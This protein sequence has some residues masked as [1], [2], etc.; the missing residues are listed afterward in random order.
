MKKPFAK[1][2]VFVLAVYVVLFFKIKTEQPDFVYDTKI[3]LAQRDI[4][5]AKTEIPAQSTDREFYIW[6]EH[7]KC[8]QREI[9]QGDIQVLFSASADEN[10]NIVIDEILTVTAT[11]G[12]DEYKFIT[13]YSKAYFIE[14]QGT[15]VVTL[16]G[17][18]EKQYTVDRVPFI[19]YLPGMFA[20]VRLTQP[21]WWNSEN[22]VFIIT[23]EPQY[24]QQLKDN[25]EFTK[26][27]VNTRKYDY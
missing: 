11:G 16:M 21:G 17:D 1:I 15:A 13:E 8:K 23:I 3:T 7:F 12:D 10:G 9:F 4:T 6:Q 5:L 18:Y 19:K 22:I 2:V 14:E 27:I 25:G 20:K 24:I 26:Q